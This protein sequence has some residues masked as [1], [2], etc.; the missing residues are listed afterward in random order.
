MNITK[1]TERQFSRILS[2]YGKDVNIDGEP[3]KVLFKP[4]KSKG[5]SEALSI[6]Y[7]QSYGWN[8]GTIFEFRGDYYLIINRDCSESDVYY[9]SIAKKCNVTMFGNYHLVA[10]ELSS[11]NPQMGRMTNSISGNVMI[12]TC[13]SKM[14]QINDIVKEFGGF[15]KCVNT[16]DIDGLSYY[17]FQRALE[18]SQGTWSLARKTSNTTFKVGSSGSVACV[19]QMQSATNV[20]YSTSA[21]YTYSSSDESIAF[22][23]SNGNVTP[24]K[25]GTTTITCKA[26]DDGEEY[27]LTFDINVVEVGKEIS[28]TCNGTKQGVGIG[29][30]RTLTVTYTKNNILVT[31]TPTWTFSGSYAS[32]VTY[33]QPAYNQARI[34]MGS[35]AQPSKLRCTATYSDG[36][37]AYIDLEVYWV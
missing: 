3:Y 25:V 33:T 26:V 2:K 34:T 19:L 5:A 1:A 12:Y 11:P 7:P 17:Y 29:Q 37:S 13:L 28:I 15:Y 16:F 22:V 27:K 30:S 31:E 9:T 36:T 14:L 21:T 6:G 32:K 24:K 4:S 18:Y 20:Y 8:K 23:D 35:S 10:G